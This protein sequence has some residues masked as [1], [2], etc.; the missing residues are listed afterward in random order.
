MSGAI[1]PLPLMKPASST[2]VAPIIADAPAPLVKVSVVPIARAAVS[3]PQGSAC[4]TAA[5]P[6]RALS[7]GSGTPMTPV[8]DTKTCSSRHPNA[9]ATCATICS[10]AS[11]P[12]WPVKALE[13]PALTISARALPCL[14]WMR[15]ISTSLEAQADLVKT[16]ATAV[17]SASSAKVRSARFQSLY[18]ARATR[19][20]T[21]SI[22]G[23]SGKVR[24]SGEGDRSM[25]FPIGALRPWVNGEAGWTRG[26]TRPI[27]TMQCYAAF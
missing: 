22:D 26:V 16:P 10:T 17:P 19:N 18:P 2:R 25:L 1:I 14:T 5:T 21:P 12:R 7:R 4:S 8:E 24:A 13:L 27:C 23:S 20:V 11:R 3:Q 6:S 9:L 15:P